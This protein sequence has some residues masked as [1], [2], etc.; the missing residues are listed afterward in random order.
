M[1]H[2][3]VVDQDRARGFL[4]TYI[5]INLYAEYRLVIYRLLKNLFEIIAFFN[6][7]RSSV[8]TSCRGFIPERI[9]RMDSPSD[10][11]SKSMYTTVACTSNFSMVRTHFVGGS[12]SVQ[13]VV[14]T[15]L[16]KHRILL[17]FYLLI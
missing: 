6:N 3:K 15:Q 8:L 13:A 1:H 10:L 16:M 9:L 14:Q 5:I 12:L 2:V 17:L 4:P 7:K 11:P